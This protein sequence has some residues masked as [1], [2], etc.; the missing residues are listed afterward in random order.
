VS[1]RLEGFDWD[2]GN[3]SKCAEHGVS[4]EEIEAVFQGRMMVSPDVAHSQDESRY[5]A[6]G[7]TPAGR[8]VFIVFTLRN[9]KIR[10]LSARYMHAKEIQK[11]EKDIR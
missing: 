9:E 3:R 4:V 8:A 6:V 10:P 5:R 1:N 11:Y 7:K 2:E